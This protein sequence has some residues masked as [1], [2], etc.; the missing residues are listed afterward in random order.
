M[1]DL[2]TGSD[3]ALSRRI[4]D[5]LVER[6]VAWDREVELATGIGPTDEDSAVWIEDQIQQE[7]D[8]LANQRTR[9]GQPMLS[10]DAEAALA[11]A[12]RRRLQPIRLIMDLLSDPRVENVSINNHRTT[13]IYYGDGTKRR[14]PAMAESDA[15]LE[16]LA[17]MCGIRFARS[18]RRFDQAH[19]FLD[20]QLADGSR[21]HAIMA[22]TDGVAIS[23]RKHQYIHVTLA[24]LIAKGTV[25]PD[26][27]AFLAAAI[28]KP[29]PANILIAG[30]TDAGKTTLLRA[31]LSEIDF[32][33]R[34]VTIE[35]PLELMLSDDP[36]R[37]DL[38]ELEAREPN[39]EGQGEI[40]IQQLVRQTKRMRAD[41]IIVG[42]VRGEEVIDMLDA[43]A[44]GNDGSLSTIHADSARAAIQRVYS[45]G[46]RAG[47]PQQATASVLAAAVHLIV[48]VKKIRDGKRVITGVVELTGSMTDDGGV[49]TLE[50]WGPGADSRA[51]KTGVQPTERLLER[52]AAGGCDWGGAW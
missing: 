43:M 17:R 46:W 37:D 14:G 23:I 25:D 13:W 31:L 33:E 41:R 3:A 35:D 12:V 38:L 24:D 20:V 51:V 1:D 50:L 5:L 28:R 52:L 21:L 6:Q 2:L 32:S 9:N 45:F 34:L 22:V 10:M 7:L 49:Q 19:P 16:D 18:E 36:R 4:A 11:E 39:V 29:E 40:T 26:L 8:A 15:E 27:A 44:T 47:M 42:E 48:H 30:G